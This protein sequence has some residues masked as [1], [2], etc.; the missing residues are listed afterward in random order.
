MKRPPAT[1]PARAAPPESLKRGP[2]KGTFSPL[3]PGTGDSSMMRSAPLLLALG[4]LA[5]GCASP[6]RGAPCAAECVPA[7]DGFGAVRRDLATGAP[8]WIAP[9]A[10]VAARA[11][12]FLP[13]GSV[14]RDPDTG[15]PLYDEARGGVVT[16]V[17]VS[18]P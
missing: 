18:L 15:A 6:G 8:I 2:G 11:P 10:D 1:P 14:A 3:G 13:D 17:L 12:R 5:A 9:A 7:F 4:A 16:R